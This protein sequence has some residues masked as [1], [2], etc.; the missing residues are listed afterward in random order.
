MFQ[1]LSLNVISFFEGKSQHSLALSFR[2][3]FS[4]VYIFREVF[5]KLVVLLINK[6]VLLFLRYWFKE[7]SLAMCFRLFKKI[8]PA[9]YKNR[10]KS[11]RVGVPSWKRMEGK[12][13]DLQGAD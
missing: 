8:L 4:V 1:D 3:Y 10:I 2:A 5:T 12:A 7:T 13:P 6:I 11:I 9:S